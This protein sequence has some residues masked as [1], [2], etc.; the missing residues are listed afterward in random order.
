MSP[1]PGAPRPVVVVGATGTGKTAAA[2]GLARRLG[3]ELVGADSVQVYRGFDVGSAKPTA[4]ELAG[5]PHHLLDVLDPPE[6]LDAM[7]W[8]RLAERACAEVEARGRIP[9]VV[10]G[11]G[12]WIRALLRGLVDVP[13][14]DP[15][16][17]AALEARA[18]AEGPEALHARLRVVD[19]LAA[20]GIH[21]RDAV[22]IVR[23]LEVF[24][25]TGRP[26][27]ALR[28]A[29][30]LGAPRLDAYVVRLEVPRDAHGAHLG[31]RI[32]AMLA[33]GWLDEIA[34]IVSRWGAAVRPLRSVGYRQLLPHVLG[35]APLDDARRA[36][37]KATRDY[38][39]R[40]RNWFAREPPADLVTD[41]EA[42]LGGCADAAVARFRGAG[43]SRG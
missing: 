31:A 43:G 32:D 2:L 37:A 23:A 25:Q 5:V 14:P 35:E 16:I 29:H 6:A 33:A 30:A 12:L 18:R 8:A 4:E 36:A 28:A 10:G 26:L 39:R 7:A 27:G 3:G 20:T 38:A 9:I 21:P 19:P 11:T 42:V 40:Q 41:A 17:R 34:G 24:E 1:A 13:A 15:V 22:R